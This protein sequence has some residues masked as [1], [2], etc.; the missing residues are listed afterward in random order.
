MTPFAFDAHVDTLQLALDLDADLAVGSPGQLDLPRAREGG[1]GG[2]VLT[3]WVHPKFD[4][5]ERGGSR[6]RAEALLD[7]L[8]RLAERHPDLV[9]LIHTRSDWS[10]AR[11]S[12]RFAAVAGMEGG[13]P[14]EDSLETL[15]H[16]ASRGLRVLTLV[17][18]NHLT[19]ARSCQ[20][21]APEGTPEGLSSFGEHIV[22]RCN[23]LGILVDL[24]HAGEQTFFDA[25]ESGEGPA[26]ASHSGCK[27]LHDHP[28]NLTD[29]QVRA[30]A[31]TGGVVGLPFLPSFLDRGAQERAARCRNTPGYQALRS[32]T[33]C[34]LEVERT[35]YLAS[36]LE[37]LGIERLVDHAAHIAELVGAEHVGLGSDFDGIATTV[38]GL[39]DARGYPRLVEPL[40]ARGFSEAE[41]EGVLGGNLERVLLEVLPD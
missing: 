29:E 13:H 26:I 40:L 7:E 28:R 15:E 12:G 10:E 32:A 35:R 8:D 4:A 3:A 25:L 18:N 5:P 39:E 19:W 27:A 14:L 17:W 30:L 33:D 41:V 9:Q 1:L 24:S 2:A 16:F 6:A 34:G 23:E 36:Q 20:P 37:P 31:A 22:G 38:A 21:D 11:V